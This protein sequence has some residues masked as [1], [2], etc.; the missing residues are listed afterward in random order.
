MP[1]PPPI[2]E[3]AHKILYACVRELCVNIIKHAG[4]DEAR[5]TMKRANSQLQIVVQDAGAGFNIQDEKTAR[6]Q[7]GEFGL[8]N[9]KERM[10]MLGGDC[11]IKSQPGKGTQVTLS[12]PA[13]SRAYHW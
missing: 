1:P 5:I 4:I 3:E 13:K 12:V 2:S 11:T 7:T 6:P 8:F 10:E 9:I